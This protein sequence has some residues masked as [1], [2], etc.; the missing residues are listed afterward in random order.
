MKKIYS[1]LLLAVTTLS[2][3]QIL[4][5]D[6]NYA[7]N[8][9]LTANGWTAHSGTTN[10]IDV[11]ASNGLLYAGYNTAANNAARLDNTGED[12][13]KPFAAA[14]NS[15][16]LYSSFLV[17]VTAAPGVAAGG[18][19]A[20]LGTGTTFVS[21]VYVRASATPNKINFGIANS[22]TG[23]FSST[24]FDLNTTY[25]II[26][27]YDVTATGGVS[28]WVKAAGVP[29]TE[30]AAGTPDATASG[31]GSTNIGGFYLRQFDATQNITVD[32]VKV[33]TTWFGAAP[34]ALTLG[35]EAV[36]CDNVTINTDT[37]NINIP[38]SGGG[39]GTYNLSVN[40]GT[41]G[42][43]DPS[44]QTDGDIIITNV[45][46]GT[47]IVLTVTGACSFTK[48][49]TSPECK[50]VNGIPYYEPFAYAEASNLAQS[51]Q[52]TNVTNGGDEII[53][54]GG[55]LT[56]A[57]PGLNPS[58]TGYTVFGGVGN[59]SSSPITSTNTGTL[60]YSLIMNVSSMA[61]VTETNGGYFAAFTSSASNHGATLWTKRVDDG[62]YNLGL[63]VRTAT[64]AATTWTTDAYTAGQTVF[65]VV[66]Y[67]FGDPGT[68][69]DDIVN[70]WVNPTINGAQ[71]AATISDTHT[72]TDLT[73]ISGFLLRQD[74]ATETPNMAVDELRIG[75]TWTQV[76]NGTLAVGDNTIA[77]L[78]MYPNPV[79]NGTLFIETAANAEKTVTVYDVL[80][81]QV[82]NT[83][84][85]D[86]AINVAGLHAG[87]YIV[88]IT[89]EGKT[90]ARK[91][92]IR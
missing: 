22:N 83:T 43:A 28:L 54:A 40:A 44:T 55:T 7:D 10:F 58:T 52:W 90:A 91:L 12:V 26:V 63:E 88:N 53:V 74:S 64:G 15:G 61:G 85:S 77:G 49:I 21:K 73:A 27:K 30:G 67:T 11:G 46:E 18:Y 50:P 92:V 38:F 48:N 79:S 9:L 45:P 1:L 37:Y 4:T 47:N 25:L 33:Y 3:G 89:E 56:P 6:F 75:T 13:N 78:K 42:G 35:T 36:T 41:L 20:H 16:T 24:D 60:Y 32:E 59:D 81:K 87:V 14:V 31:S 17:N 5:D 62:V 2:F 76:T 82:L 34:C 80:G 84:T 8:S 19:F 66:G 86:S 57:Y 71:P 70:L 69:S 65:V 68:P 29:A 51:Q 23:T 39:T 72:G